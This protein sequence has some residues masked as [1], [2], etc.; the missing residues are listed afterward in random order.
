MQPGD[1]FTR[2]Y[3]LTR[4]YG[5]SA[6][7]TYNV[8]LVGNDGTFSAPVTVTLKRNQ[9]TELVVSVNAA[10]AGKHAAILNLDDPAHPGV[11]AQ[12]MNVVI[13]APQL[14]EGSP[15]VTYSGRIG[16]NQTTS[17]FVDVPAGAPAFVV[18]FSGPSGKSKTGEARFL[19]ITPYGTPL[20]SSSSLSCYAPPPPGGSCAG[21]TPY[22]RSVSAPLPGVWEVEVEARRTSDRTG[23]PYT[24][25]MSVLGASVTPDPDE[26]TAASGDVVE[27]TYTATNLFGPFVGEAVGSTMASA[28]LDRPTI[29]DLD[30]RSGS[31][32]CRPGRPVCGR[33]SAGPATR[34]RTSTCSSSTAPP[35]AA[36]WPA[37]APTVTARR[38]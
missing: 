37:S 25:T 20:E 14:V 4:R 32:T 30:S 36:T 21:G 12:T 2:T 23:T 8:N 5:G 10:T 9:P 15:R 3:T 18:S 1:T 22:Q 38:R 19:R 34:R 16:R 7:I 33:R 35:A 13:A 6:P 27:R 29:A 24:L 17:Y 11:E 28:F 26:I 31:S